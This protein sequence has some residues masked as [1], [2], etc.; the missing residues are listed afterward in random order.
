MFSRNSRE[1]ADPATADLRPLLA[2]IEE[3]IGSGG[4]DQS[5]ATLV[6]EA[7][8]PRLSSVTRSLTPDQLAGA[9]DG[10]VTHTLFASDRFSIVIAVFLP[11]QATPI[12]DHVTWC[13]V[14]VLCGVEHETIYALADQNPVPVHVNDNPT[15][16]VTGF[17]PPGDIHRVV[18][19]ID[20]VTVSMHVYGTNIDRVGSS[21]R[22]IYAEDAP[23]DGAVGR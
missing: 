5:T 11:G 9:P 17:A 16:S 19:V 2:S 12:H 6:A 20:D 13:V 8:R 4:D 10:Y 18:N 14:G 23:V 15:G 1:V 7:V 3:A 22:R 21:V